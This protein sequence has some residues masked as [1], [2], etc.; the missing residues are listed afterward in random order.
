M[1]ANACV[2]VCMRACVYVCEGVRGCFSLHHS[3]NMY[4]LQYGKN[5]LLNKPPSYNHHIL[6]CL[7]FTFIHIIYIIY[8]FTF[9]YVICA[10][11]LFIFIL[12]IFTGDFDPEAT[13]KKLVPPIDPVEKHIPKRKYREDLKIIL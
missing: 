2:Y 6:F 3:I 4:F 7:T 9:I 13:S 8:L 12:I 10:R 1:R 5:N 11:N